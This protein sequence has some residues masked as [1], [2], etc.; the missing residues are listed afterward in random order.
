MSKNTKN[1]KKDFLN[2]LRSLQ[3]RGDTHEGYTTSPAEYYEAAYQAAYD[4]VLKNYQEKMRKGA[5]S[6]KTR[7]YLYRWNYEVDPK[8]RKYKFKGVRILDIVTKGNLIERLTTHF[9]KINSE[10]TVGWHKFKNDDSSKPTR[11]GIYVSWAEPISE[12]ADAEV[13]V[14]KAVDATREDD[15]D[16]SSNEDEIEVHV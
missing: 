5:E 15:S 12:T 1:T 14:T 2:E 3:K 6:G 7:A 11:Y 13:E 9:Q 10:F 8:S 4:F 16:N